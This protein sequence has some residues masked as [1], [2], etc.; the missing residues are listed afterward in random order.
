MNQVDQSPSRSSQPSLQSHARRPQLERL[1]RRIGGTMR[2]VCF[3]AGVIVLVILTY[4]KFGPQAASWT[5]AD[6]G[7]LASVLLVMLVVVM[8]GTFAS[9]LRTRLVVL[10]FATFIALAILETYL[11]VLDPFPILLRGGRISLPANSERQFAADGLPGLEDRITVRFNSLGFRGPE[12]PADWNERLTIVCVGGSTTQCIYLSEGTTWPDRLAQKLLADHP[13]VWLN[14]AGLDGHSTFGHLQLLEQYLAGLHPKLILFYMGLNDVDRSD[15]N[16]SDLS[17]VRTEPQ[18][19][20]SPVR[21]IQR[22]LLRFSDTF[23][24]MDN[25]RMQWLAHRKGLTHGE[26]IA[27]RRLSELAASEPLSEPTGIDSQVAASRSAWLATRDPRS[28]AGYEMRVRKLVSRC[29]EL[30]IGCVLIT[31]PVLYGEGI[32]DV[33]GVNLERVSVGDTDGAGHWQ[34]LKLYNQ[35]TTQV[36][37]ELNVPLIDLANLMPKSSRYFYDLTHYNL[38]GAEQAANLIFQELSPRLHELVESQ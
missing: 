37:S 8:P 30:K 7:L 28:L 17:T 6:W 34:L 4:A 13:Q 20:D 33:T 24:L 27:H 9:G 26:P 5:I 32:D 16:A 36:A 14:N 21:A 25:F 31:Q 11:R 10:G 35:A 38:A 3:A 15:L 2:G 22:T 29:R 18:A 19:S 12:P 23:A 1:Q